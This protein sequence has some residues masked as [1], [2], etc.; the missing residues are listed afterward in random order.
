[1]RTY[2][3][4]HQNAPQFAPYQ[5]PKTPSILSPCHCSTHGIISTRISSLLV[6][7]TSPITFLTPLNAHAA[8]HVAALAAPPAAPPAGVARLRAGADGGR[9]A[10]G[11]G[12]RAAPPRRGPGAAGGAAVAARRAA[13][14]APGRAA[15]AP[16]AE[17]RPRAARLRDPARRAGN[18]AVVLD[19]PAYDALL[20]ALLAAK[21]VEEAAE[22]LREVVGGDDVC[23]TEQTF[24]PVLVELVKARE[25]DEATELMTRG[26]TRG[27]EFTSETFHPLLVLAE[28]DTAS[29]DS[30]IKFLSFV[31]DSWEEYKVGNVADRRT[32][33]A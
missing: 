14:A 19:L 24:L 23:P 9:V 22:I 29:T 11:A 25:Y 7:A 12:D 33:V 27:V 6:V 21:R 26:Q 30:L 15:G 10:A 20:T 3:P 1:M 28:K 5:F 13:A 31:E 8:P 4:D 2:S 16:E 18:Q 32:N 17:P